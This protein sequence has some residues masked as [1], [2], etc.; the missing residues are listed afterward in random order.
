MSNRPKAVPVEREHYRAYPEPLSTRSGCKVGWYTYATRA[1]AETA[2]EAARWNA[3]L[4]AA[5][6]HDFGYTPPGTIGED[7]DGT[8]TVTIP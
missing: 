2:A 6:G 8:F 5:Y 7:A 4:K 1:E 3:S